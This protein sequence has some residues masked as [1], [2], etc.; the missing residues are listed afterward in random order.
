MPCYSLV[1]GPCCEPDERGAEGAVE[2]SSTEDPGGTT[3]PVGAASEED[4]APGSR[5]AATWD[6]D[7]GEGAGEAADDPGPTGGAGGAASDGRCAPDP[8]GDVTALRSDGAGESAS[9][10]APPPTG[11]HIK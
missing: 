3:D 8:E 7:G 10:G 4:P 6:D 11:E 5:C 1:T 9:A 2:T